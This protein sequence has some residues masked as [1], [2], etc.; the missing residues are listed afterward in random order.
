VGLLSLRQSIYFLAYSLFKKGKIFVKTRKN[1]WDFK[2][3]FFSKI[4]F[5]NFLVEKGPL[6]IEI[7]FENSDF[8]P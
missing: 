6:K 7:L 3:L 2:D 8:W 4:L 1:T 5:Q